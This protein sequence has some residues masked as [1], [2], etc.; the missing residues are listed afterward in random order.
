V[1]TTWSLDTDALTGNNH[2]VAVATGMMLF[3]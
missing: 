1:T 2:A 3:F